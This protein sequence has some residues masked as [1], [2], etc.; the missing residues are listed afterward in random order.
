MAHTVPNENSY[1]DNRGVKLR[2]LEVVKKDDNDND[3]DKEGGKDN[4][5]E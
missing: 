1:C 4:R 2:L 3:N 5:E